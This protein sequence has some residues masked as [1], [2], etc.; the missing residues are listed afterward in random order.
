MII[1]LA[2]R[3]HTPDTYA[4]PPI[5]YP[6]PRTHVPERLPSSLSPWDDPPQ[7]FVELASRWIKACEQA[8]LT[9]TGRTHEPKPLVSA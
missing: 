6:L 1:D 5:W 2:S 4:H 9:A 3:R 7:R 8:W